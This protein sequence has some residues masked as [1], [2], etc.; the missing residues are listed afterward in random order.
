[1]SQP[2]K[3]K[4]Y[5]TKTITPEKL[6]EMYN[7]LDIKLTG[8]IGIKIH[9]GEKG[10]KNFIRPEFIKPIVDYLDGTIIETNTSG[11]EAAS[12]RTTNE[13]HKKLLEEHG[14]TKV[15]KKVEILD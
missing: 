9:S 8:N 7:K 4:V 5:F 11:P 6:I 1:M 2:Q 10:N 3:P 12:E 13:K 15:F 14:W